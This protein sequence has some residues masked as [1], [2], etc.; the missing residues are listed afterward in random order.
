MVSD[1]DLSEVDELA[2]DLGHAA[3]GIEMATETGVLSVVGQHLK[4]DAIAAAPVHTGDLKASIYLR[5]G[6]GWR[7]VGSDLKQGFFQ[8]HGTSVMPPQP[9]LYPAAG[10]AAEELVAALGE[11]ADPL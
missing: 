10:K 2:D 6:K 8:E 4:A 5:G 7:Q 3:A 9:W 11:I 1:F